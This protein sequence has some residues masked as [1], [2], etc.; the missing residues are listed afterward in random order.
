MIG[1]CEKCH[2]MVECSAREVNKI[3]SIKGKEITYTGK[4]A[5]CSECGNEIFVADVRDYNLR[6]LD[7]VFR[8]QEK[9]I[10]V[11]DIKIILEKYNIGKRPL[12]LLLN[13]GEGT[14]T[15][16]LNGDIPTK[17]YSEALKRILVDSNYMAEILEQNKDKIKNHA[18]SLCKQ[19]LERIE[20]D[21]VQKKF[22]LENE[23]KIESVVKYL[24]I[25]CSE[26][27]PLALQKLLYYAQ[28]FY[29]VFHG[30]YLFKEDCEAWVHGPVYRN[31]YHK[32]KDHGYN[33][34]EENNSEY[35]G[36]V[37]TEAEKEIID[38]ITTNFGCYSGKILERM[39]HIETPWRVTRKGL[40]E[41][42]SSDRII[43]K[44]LIADYFSGIK[45][46]YNMLNISDIKDYSADLFK[47]LYY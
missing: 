20:N 38:S 17:Q 25:H 5:Y 15:R 9:L 33:P 41:H 47:K 13:W 16:Y 39:T 32:Y 11:S 34:I 24:L 35:E 1:F 3:K 7:K 43:N 26:I 23:G 18:Y 42:E 30:E 14:V 40:G 10:P 19:A 21:T 37:L 6:M 44:E 36:F 2:D 12:S 29:K 4:E 8:E 45:S 27:T 22:E 28:G 31:V 46:K